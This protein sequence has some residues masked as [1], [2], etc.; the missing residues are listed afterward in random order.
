MSGRA[1][2]AAAGTVLALTLTLAACSVPPTGRTPV[3]STPSTPT[4][5]HQRDLAAAYVDATMQT[6]GVTWDDSQANEYAQECLLG[7]GTSGALDNL[8]RIGAGVPD[9]EAAVRTVGRSWAADGLTVKYSKS[10]LND[11]SREFVVKGAG[12]DVER[13]EFGAASTR[14]SL[15]AV[16]HC[17]TGDAADLG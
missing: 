9:P 8:A 2:G 3:Q 7:D 6:S 14:S 10:S 13:I 5:Q 16:S 4:V 17:G 15:A 12:G 11:G 1:R